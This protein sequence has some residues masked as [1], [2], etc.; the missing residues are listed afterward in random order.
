MKRNTCYSGHKRAHTHA[1]THAH[2]GAFT[3]EL[4]LVNQKTAIR[5]DSLFFLLLTQSKGNMHVGLYSPSTETVIKICHRTFDLVVSAK[6]R[7]LTYLPIFIVRLKF[8]CCSF[9]LENLKSVSFTAIAR[10]SVYSCVYDFI[11]YIFA[12]YFCSP[13]SF[14]FVSRNGQN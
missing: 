6:L 10:I 7:L 5:L 2:S 12:V 11:L 4:Y 3:H 13:L 14:L 9:F 1:R 8:H